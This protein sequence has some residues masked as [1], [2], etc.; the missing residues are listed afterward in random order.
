MKTPDSTTNLM[1]KSALAPNAS[2]ALKW[3]YRPVVLKGF[4]PF[5]Q[6]FESLK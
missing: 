5:L 4:T 3:P 1:T 2:E 6:L